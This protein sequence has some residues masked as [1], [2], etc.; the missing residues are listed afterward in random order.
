MKINKLFRSLIFCLIFSSSLSYA[1]IKVGTVFFSPPFVLSSES[2]FS[3]DLINAI[4]L[5]LKQQCTLYQM[6]F[7][8]LFSALDSGKIDIAIG[9]I[10]IPPK[11]QTDYI[12]SLPY[13]LSEGE[14][15]IKKNKGNIY[16]SIAD[17]K[18]TTIGIL[19]AGKVKADAD[20]SFYYNYLT[21]TYLNQFKIDEYESMESVFAALS[22][23]EIAAGFSN[24]ALANYWIQTN[25][26]QFQILGNPVLLGNGIGV[27]SVQKNAGLIKQINQQ[28]EA[29]ES[30]GTFI[31][32]Y[33]VY[34]SGQ[35]KPLVTN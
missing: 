31:K 13:M 26:D 33:S 30:D 23:D 17:L 24:A 3:I 19:N 32:I 12:Y 9:G 10:S 16:K 20:K 25:S 29:M 15:F 28:L 14:F 22:N 4:C 5:R 6:P 34:F 1:D 2:G 21:S 35:L 11:E 8:S 18:G 7:K 27:M